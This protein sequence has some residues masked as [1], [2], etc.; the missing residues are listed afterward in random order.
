MCPV[1]V[2]AKDNQLLIKAVSTNQKYNAAKVVDFTLPQSFLTTQNTVQDGVTT[3]DDGGGPPNQDTE[4]RGVVLTANAP[5]PPTVDAHS[6]ADLTA[7][8]GVSSQ[9]SNLA[10]PPPPGELEAHTEE[11]PPLPA[12][13]AAES[14]APLHPHDVTRSKKLSY[15]LKTLLRLPGHPDT[16]LFGDSHFSHMDG[17]EVDPDGD[18][19]RVRA[20]G[21]LCVPAAVYAIARHKYTHKKI[22]RVVWNLGT[23]GALHSDQHCAAD[24]LKYLRLL[25][26]ESVRVFPKATIYFITPFIGM[27]GVSSQYID[28]L[29]AD[30]KRAAP[31]MVIVKPPSMLRKFSRSGVHLNN[32]GRDKFIRFLRSQF[33]VKEQRIFSK[34]SGRRSHSEDGHGGRYLYSQAHLPRDGN[35]SFRVTPP[36][37][38]PVPNATGSSLNSAPR[39]RS[40]TGP[41]DTSKTVCTTKHDTGLVN[42]IASKVMEIITQQNM[43]YRYYPPLPPPPTNY[44]CHTHPRY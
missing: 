21:G 44:P 11:L 27:A 1:C 33:V 12:S 22:K 16:G 41:G 14:L 8:T 2:I 6:T 36:A 25:H 23:N 3:R 15:V 42:D 31:N 40:E 20:V 19:V 9:H 7:T 32:S 29:T 37:Q 35:Q 18:K 38:A 4:V 43:M 24:R 5:E 13:L 34:D 28:E 26:S 17:K 39:P 10:A 30:I